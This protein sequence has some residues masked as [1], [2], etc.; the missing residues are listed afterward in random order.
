MGNQLGNLPI[1]TGGDG[2][3][4]LNT[5][6][7]TIK[8]PTKF[9]RKMV[10]SSSLTKLPAWL[11][12]LLSETYFNPCMIHEDAKK[13]EK[14]IFCLDCCEAICH[15][16]L[17]RHTSHRLLQIRRY[18]YHDVIRV[19]DAEKLIDCSYV[20]ACITNSAKVVFL[21]PRPQTRACRGSSNNCVSC[22]RGLQEPYVFCSISCKGLFCSH[23]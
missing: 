18:V 3:L 4:A 1:K 16:C 5:L 23:H 21:N 2:G 22:D 14:N 13:N 12:F 19:G 9:K 6:F 11:E 8:K 7:S 20:Q 17:D 15:H 10:E